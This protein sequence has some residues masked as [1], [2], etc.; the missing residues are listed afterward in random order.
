M[1]VSKVQEENMIYINER[2]FPID[3]DTLTGEQI[4]EIGGFASNEYDLYI[5]HD[6]NKSKQIQNKETI[7][8]R[9][10]LRF[11]AVLKPT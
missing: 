2:G 11:N 3:K 9:N 7:K 1:D 4:L 8:I 6:P 5:L 10:R